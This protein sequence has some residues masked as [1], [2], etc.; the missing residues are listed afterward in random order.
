MTNMIWATPAE[1]RTWWT[2]QQAALA[3]T[4][5]ELPATDPPVQGLIDT[6]TRT[7]ESKVIRWPIL[8]D[9]ERAED[10]AQRAH[11]IAA[12]GETIRARRDNDTAIAQL[13]GTGVAAV[14]A[15]GGSIEASKLR[16]TGGRGVLVGASNTQRVPIEAYEAL[17]AAG[18]IGGSVAS[19]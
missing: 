5:P 14:L 2:D 10:E 12:V 16:A 15:A 6:A 7:L 13:G 9:Q 3:V 4:W 11:L 17:Q 19:W 1:V 18:L 8:N